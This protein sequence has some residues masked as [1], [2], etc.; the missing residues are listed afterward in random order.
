MGDDD[1]D[2]D[3]MFAGAFADDEVETLDG[4]S[5]R[6]LIVDHKRET[7]K[8]LRQETADELV[9]RLPRPGEAY[10]IVSNGS[11][12]YWNLVVAI[13]RMLG[14]PVETFRASTWTMNRQN[15]RELL[16]MIDDGTLREVGFLTGIYFKRRETAVYANLMEGLTNRGHR[17]RCLENHAKVAVLIAPPDFIVLEGSANFTANPRIEQN[18]IANCQTLAEFHL[19]WMNEILNHE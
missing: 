8:R 19:A 3:A 12:D 5:A 6:K 1:L 14:R 10:H 2:L 18:I 4:I 15:V 9:G 13:T 11:F 17:L 16:G 7:A